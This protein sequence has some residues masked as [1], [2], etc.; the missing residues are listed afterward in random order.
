MDISSQTALVP[1]S[2]RHSTRSCTLFR[3]RS[4]HI[5]SS[6]TSRCAGTSFFSDTVVLVSARPCSLMTSSPA[7]EPVWISSL[8]TMISSSSPKSAAISSRGS[9]VVSGRENHTHPSP[10]AVMLMKTFQS[11]LE[12]R[13]VW[14]A[15]TNQIELPAN[16]CKRRAGHFKIY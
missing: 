11:Q 14:I 3:L 12:S 13:R 6:T 2:N 7:A 4:H 9:P 1:S 16:I 8:K 10:T 15:S 5:C